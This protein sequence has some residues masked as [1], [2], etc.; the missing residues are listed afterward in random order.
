LT[1]KLINL[2]GVFVFVTR[3]YH[4]KQSSYFSTVPKRKTVCAILA[5]IL[6]LSMLPIPA[7]AAT[8]TTSPD[9]TTVI[10]SVQTPEPMPEVKISGTLTAE[11]GGTV[12]PLA[13]KA[14]IIDTVAYENLTPDAEYTLTGALTDRES[15]LPV[16]RNG[17]PVTVRM[18][19]TPTATSGAVELRFNF[20][21][22]AIGGRT[23][24]VLETLECAGTVVF[25][26]TEIADGELCVAVESIEPPE[27]VKPVPQ[28]GDDGEGADETAPPCPDVDFDTLREANPDVTA[29]LSVDGTP[30]DYPVAQSIDNEWYLKH[31]PDGER[32]NAGTPF[33]DF[34]NSPRYTDRNNIIY[35]HNMRNGTMFACLTKYRRQEYY[36]AH[37]AMRLLTPDGN[38]SVEV[39]AAFTASPDEAGAV[40]SPWRQEWDSDGDFIAWLTRAQ[41][42]SVIECGSVPEAGDRVLTLSTCINNGRDRFVVMGRLIPRE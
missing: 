20:D 17:N 30:I 24:A 21:S 2:E 22:R 25:T 4:N 27:P 40:T 12:V 35:G 19:F 28:T 11:G 9:T 32:D 6:C 14:V 38:F 3:V 41:E 23:L 26:H 8:A 34:E 29:W 7:M 42:R 1:I 36:D 33:L 13:E 37:P 18:V 15:G 10:T 5:A 39:F 31:R 16:T